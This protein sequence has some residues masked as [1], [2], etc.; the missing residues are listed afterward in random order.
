MVVKAK[1]KITKKKITI[2]FCLQGA[3]FFNKSLLDSSKSVVI[4]GCILQPGTFVQQSKI[5]SNFYSNSSS[6]SSSSL[7]SVFNDFYIF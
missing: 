3:A 6:C 1:T 5:E 2:F 7:L 4:S